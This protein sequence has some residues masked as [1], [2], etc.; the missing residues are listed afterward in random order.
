M[1]SFAPSGAEAIA[2][3]RAFDVGPL[4]LMEPSDCAGAGGREIVIAG[5]PVVSTLTLAGMEGT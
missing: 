1:I 4:T 5:T 2:F 3:D